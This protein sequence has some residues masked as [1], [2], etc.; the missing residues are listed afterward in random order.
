MTAPAGLLVIMGPTGSGKTALALAAAERFNG[1]IISADSMQVYRGLDIGTAKPTAAEQQAVPHH[2]VDILDFRDSLEVFTFVRLA[3]EA[4]AA[5]RSR[6]RL[7]IIA[8]GTG[9][10]LKALLYGLDPLP[11][12]ATLR[13]D[14]DRR[15]DHEAGH[16]ELIEL[17]RREDPADCERWHEHRRKLIRAYE[18]FLLTGKSITELQT[19]HQPQLRYP[20]A[21]FRLDWER[22]ALKSRIAARTEIMLEQGWGE[23]AKRLIAAGLLDSPTARQAIGY[24]IIADYLA[25]RIDYAAMRERIVTV[26]WQF[27]RRQLTWFRHQHPEAAVL[28]M[29]CTVESALAHFEQ[30][31]Q[32]LV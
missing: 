23:E 6:G 22:E 19:L 11:A 7:P 10:Y 8:G 29:P 30:A 5:I 24:P 3:D 14:L 25:G 17:M 9:F 31:L 2:L 20:T 21:A 16:R 13:A 28:P 26:T 27:A 4:I 15:F 1:E 18:V 32:L 12:D